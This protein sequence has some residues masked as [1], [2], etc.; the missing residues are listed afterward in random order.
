MNTQQ[1]LDYLADNGIL[2]SVVYGDAGN[3]GRWFSVDICLASQGLVLEKPQM[4][5]SFIEAVQ[6]AYKEAVRLEW[7]K[8]YETKRK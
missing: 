1:T 3:K 8:E 5:T 4:A 2:T 6:I 7:V